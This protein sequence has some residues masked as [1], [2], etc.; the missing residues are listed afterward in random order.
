[1]VAHD[2]QRLARQVPRY[3]VRGVGGRSLQCKTPLHRH[4]FRHLAAP[5]WSVWC[6][7]LVGLGSFSLEEIGRSKSK[8]VCQGPPQDLAS[9]SELGE[10]GAL[11][12]NLGFSIE[13]TVNC[14]C[15][16]F[17]WSLT[18]MHEASCLS[19]SSSAMQLALFGAVAGTGWENLTSSMLRA[20]SSSR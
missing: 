9:A 13:N 6:L 19:L 10:V 1:M 8:R 2:S 18:R 7:G 16:G 12:L 20:L 3:P 14:S 17:L 15:A 5:L 11:P 4:N